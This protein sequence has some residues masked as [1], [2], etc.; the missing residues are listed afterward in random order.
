MGEV[1]LAHG[2]PQQ[3]QSIVRTLLDQFWSNA[4]DQNSSYVIESAMIHCAEQ[5]LEGLAAVISSGSS[6]TVV[7][8]LRGSAGNRVLKALPKMPAHLSQHVLRIV[9]GK[10]Q[11]CES[12][13]ANNRHGK[14]LVQEL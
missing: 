3:R 2:S 14:R 10:L 13:Y 5:E 12:A 9:V 7:S 6:E 11:A 1:I 4:H 8:L